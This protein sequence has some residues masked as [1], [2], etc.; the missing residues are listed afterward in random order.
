MT[1]PREGGPGEGDGDGA[2]EG[3]TRG[4]GAPGAAE[5]GGITGCCIDPGGTFPA[6]ETAKE[7]G[8]PGG[9]CCGAKGCEFGG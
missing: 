4:C 2:G 9:C 6:C 8:P 1:I 5:D 7:T 3:S